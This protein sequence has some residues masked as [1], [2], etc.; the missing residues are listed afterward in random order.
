ELNPIENFW[1][2]MKTHVKRSTFSGDEDLKTR[3]AGA[4]NGIRAS[5]LL[6]MSQHSVD[7]SDKCLRMGPI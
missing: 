7:V 3:V 2:T 5:A 1:T 6:N 4:S